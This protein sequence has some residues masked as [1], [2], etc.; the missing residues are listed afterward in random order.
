MRFYKE[1]E[2]VS[3]EAVLGGTYT[4]QWHEPTSWWKKDVIRN[5]TY[6]RPTYVN[7]CFADGQCEVIYLDTHE[8]AE[9]LTLRIKERYSLISLKEL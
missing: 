7:A 6:T 8:E 3:V 2:V 5:E 1:K 4:R 9:A